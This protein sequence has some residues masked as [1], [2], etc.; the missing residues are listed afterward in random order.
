MDD[1]APDARISVVANGPLRVEG[2]LPLTRQRIE[3]NEQGESWD[4]QEIECLDAGMSYALCR[5]DRS[6]TK[7]FCDDA[8]SVTGWDGTE[9]AGDVPYAKQARIYPGPEVDLADA[10]GFCA[11]ARFCE[12]RGSVWTLVDEEGAEARDLVERETGHCPSGRLVTLEDAPNGSQAAVEPAFDPSVVLVEDAARG[13]SGPIWVRGGV[14]ITSA[15]G[16]AYEV[17]NRVTLC[18]CGLS[19]NKPFCDGSHVRIGA[20]NR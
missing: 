15:A 7:P 11:S 19:A 20:M 2:A 8:C 16:H 6:G 17:R 18:R 5:C 10:V 1:D 12:A 4:W 3:T 13:V 9:T 14:Q